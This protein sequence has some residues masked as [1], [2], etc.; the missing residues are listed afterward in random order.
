M[1][2]LRGCGLG[3]G[4]G[5]GGRQRGLRGC[6]LGGNRGVGHRRLLVRGAGLGTGN[7]RPA[8]GGRLSHRRYGTGGPDGDALPGRTRRRDTV[9]HRAGNRRY[10][11]G[12]RG[13]A[14]RVRC[15]KGLRRRVR[16]RGARCHRLGHGPAPAAGRG[17]GGMRLRRGVVLGLVER[18]GVV[19][20]LVTRDGRHGHGH[21]SGHL[22]LAG[23]LTGHLHLAGHRGRTGLQ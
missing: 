1:R 10:G 13:L 14:G 23:H 18:Y 5:R 7:R 16:G 2:G 6:G 8:R 3:G 21:L 19:P 15:R 22:H 11:R 17:T 4:C 20:A 9:R 12:L